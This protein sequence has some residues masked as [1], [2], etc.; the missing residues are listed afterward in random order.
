M[1]IEMRTEHE[2]WTIENWLALKLVEG[3]SPFKNL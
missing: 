2:T 1:I 3:P